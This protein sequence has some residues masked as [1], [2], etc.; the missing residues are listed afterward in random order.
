[1]DLLAD[2][3]GFRRPPAE[4]PNPS[5]KKNARKQLQFE[6]ATDEPMH[7]DEDADPA[8]P[9]KR[10]RDPPYEREPQ[11]QVLAQL[12]GAI[13]QLQ[14]QMEANQADFFFYRQSVTRG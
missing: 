12:V 7:G 8:K 6:D 1:M 14:R 5:E 4:T 2:V 3:L 13:Q 10:G 9:G 11:E